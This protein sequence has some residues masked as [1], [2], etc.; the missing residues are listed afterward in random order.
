MEDNVKDVKATTT[1]KPK[2]PPAMLVIGGILIGAICVWSGYKSFCF[3]DT[4]DAYVEGHIVPISPKVGAHVEKILIQDNQVVKAGDLLLELDVRDFDVRAV[5]AKANL[6][7]AKADEEQAKRDVDRYKTLVEK[8]ELSKQAF[9]KAELRLQTASAQ[10]AAAE[11]ALKQAEL[12]VS[13]TK[14]YAPVNGHVTKKSVEEGAFVQPGQPLLAIVSDEMWVVANFKETQ[15]G[16]VYPGQKVTMKIDTYS[17]KEFKGHVDS[18][19]R[20]TGA[21]FSMFPPENAAGNF[22][23]VVQRIPVKIV[24]D[25]A[26]D[27]RHPLRVGMSVVPEVKVR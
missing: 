22:V 17:D 3:I 25:E 14:I 26:K 19:Q 13:Y 16:N 2:I 15:L 10:R 9:D 18:I 27:D 21:S 5:M 12:N 20:G 6:D 1:G 24:F 7:A 8:E 4:D 11:A 23:K